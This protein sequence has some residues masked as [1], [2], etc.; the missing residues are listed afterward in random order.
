MQTI[1]IK[2]VTLH[3]KGLYQTLKLECQFDSGRL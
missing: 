1:E 3:L 2:G